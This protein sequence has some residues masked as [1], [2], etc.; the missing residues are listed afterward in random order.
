MAAGSFSSSLVLLLGGGNEQKK[1]QN[2]CIKFYAIFLLQKN[3]YVCKNSMKVKFFDQIFITVLT[4]QVLLF[5]AEGDK[6]EKK[7]LVIF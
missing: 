7:N 3:N 1:C 4:I 6:Y 5:I 2:A